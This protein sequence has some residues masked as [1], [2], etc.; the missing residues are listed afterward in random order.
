M[1]K[2]LSFVA[3]LLAIALGLAGDAWADKAHKHT[4]QYVSLDAAV[5]KGFD[6]FEPRSITDSGRVYGTLFQCGPDT[7]SPF[8]AVYRRGEISALHD[9]SLALTANNRGTVGGFVV[10][11]PALGTSQAALFTRSE[12]ELIPPLTDEFTAAVGLL[13]N[14]GIA[15]VTSLDSNFN[16]L[17]HY[18]TRRGHVTPLNFG[19]DFAGQFDINNRGIISG[20]SFRRDGNRAFRYDPSSGSFTVL[21][22]LPTEPDSWGQA[23][24]NRGHVLG[25]S[26]VAG[27]LER[28]GVWR[29]TEFR[30]YFVEGTDE[31]PTVSNRLLWNKRGL[32]VI[33]DTTDLN[34]YLVP[35]PG[36]RLN[37]ADL[38]EG[39]IPVWTLILD[40][41]NRGDL[42]GIG[43]AE[44]GFFDSAFLLRRVGRVADSVAA[45][46]AE[47]EVVA[48]GARVRHAPALERI[49][50]ERLYGGLGKNRTAK[51]ADLTGE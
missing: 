48:A 14:S 35:R 16:V 20:T 15:F 26:F 13:T 30:T 51:S 6:F 12:V 28:I 18:L 32:I 11:D 50:H 7:C 9:E 47:S 46:S 29:G 49:L 41:N 2:T 19:P 5:P 43:G 23:I 40:I 34:S 17:S 10:L 45:S 8:V 39:P 21:D 44:Q 4:Y 25:Y 38:T 31:F 22:P 37:L 33:T 24:N 1:N 36:V 3:G 27:G 42:I